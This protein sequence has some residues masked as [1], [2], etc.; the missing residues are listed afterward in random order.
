MNCTHD[1]LIKLFWNGGNENGERLELNEKGVKYAL[2]LALK[3]FTPRTEKRI[4]KDPF[5]AEEM[6]EE[7]EKSKSYSQKFLKFFDDDKKDEEEFDNW[8]GERCKEFF[9][10]F[11]SKYENFNQ[12]NKYGK[13]QKV[14]NMTFKYIYCL[15]GAEE[16]EKYFEFCHMPLDSIT[17]EWFYRLG[18]KGEKTNVEI[19]GK[20]IEEKIGR[21]YPSWSN[22]RKLSEG[23][24]KEKVK[25]ISYGY[26]DIQK[27]IRKYFKNKEKLTPLKAEFI[28][29]P[30][31][32]LVLASE[33][34]FSNLIELNKDYI[35]TGEIYSKILED[36][37][38]KYE[39]REVNEPT[40]KKRINKIFRKRSIKDKIQCLDEILILAKNNKQD[41]LI[42]EE[43]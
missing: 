18:E 23:D 7:L 13:A 38:K 12:K 24:K 10:V 16:K 29:W 20:K 17:L 25:V 14:I 5:G 30:Q 34:L 32:Q 43:I 27:T 8:H 40:Y 1:N 37:N 15:K 3:D 35:N 22:L 42:F 26:M 9:D 19:K 28:I 41:E 4:G 6:L 33:A 21:K 31:M 36:Y 2:L 11:S 39:N